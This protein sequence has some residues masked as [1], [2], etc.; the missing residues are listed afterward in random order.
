[1]R[2]FLEQKPVVN[3]HEH[4]KPR[5]IKTPRWALVRARRTKERWEA[6][7]LPWGA[8]TI[9]G[10]RLIW[11]RATYHVFVERDVDEA[12]RTCP[13]TKA[14]PVKAP[15]PTIPAAS[16][17]PVNTH[18]FTIVPL[19]AMYASRGVGCATSEQDRSYE[20]EEAAS[21]ERRPKHGRFFRKGV[22]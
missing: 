13:R 6:T 2:L 12:G 1:M 4:A 17:T 15:E 7:F 22:L 3:T 21:E 19:G 10:L 5:Q 20:R 11:L 16:A 8:Q 9:D 14:G 18:G